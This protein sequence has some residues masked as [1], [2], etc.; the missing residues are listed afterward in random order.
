MKELTEQR[1]KKLSIRLRGIAK[2]YGIWDYEGFTNDYF[3][4]ILS[5]K[6]QKQTLNQFAIDW[7]RSRLGRPSVVSEK[8]TRMK[9][10]FHCAASMSLDSG[11]TMEVSVSDSSYERM[12]WEEIFQELQITGRQRGML[13]LSIDGYKM[14]EIAERYLVTESRVSQVLTSVR[15]KIQLILDTYEEI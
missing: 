3:V 12:K 13:L 2:K 6:G 14:Y 7:L 8:T 1:I 9:A 15:A 10:L 11:D 4:N 5:G